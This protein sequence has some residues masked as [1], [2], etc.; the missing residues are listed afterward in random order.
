MSMSWTDK[1]LPVPFIDHGRGW[2]GADCF[3][4]HILMNWVEKKKPIPDAGVSLGG[5]A[6]GVIKYVH[7]CQAGRDGWQKV[8]EADL[9]RLDLIL[10][11]GIVRQKD[12]FV[13][14]G[15]V[16]VGTYVGG[17][18][19]NILHTESGRGVELVSL[20]HPRIRVRVIGFYR[21][22]EADATL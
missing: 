20:H 16:H 14:N 22:C 19:H 2:D 6:K 3:G 11:K 12:G 13:F 17:E 5:S 1:Y 4:L 21:W 18:G 8:E 10:M 9:Q 7:E 15:D